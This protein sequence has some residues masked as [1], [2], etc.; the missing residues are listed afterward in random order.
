MR[1]TRTFRLACICLTAL[2]STPVLADLYR[3]T[4]IPLGP[5][6]GGNYF[7]TYDLNNAGQVVGGGDA[8]GRDR[9]WLW[10]GGELTIV[11]P[12]GGGAAELAAINS[13]GLAVGS[14]TING[15]LD[16]HAVLWDG[17]HMKDLGLPPGASSSI[18]RA[19]ND[20]GQVVVE[21]R[22]ANGAVR[23]YLWNG[24]SFID[25]GTLGAPVMR[26]T[27]INL[28]GHVTGYSRATP[29]GVNSAVVWNG[30]TLIDLGSLVP[31]RRSSNAE[32]INN[33]GQVAGWAQVDWGYSQAFLW[34]GSTAINL[35]TLGGLIAAAY[36]VN[37][38]GQVVG[39]S[40][41]VS[42]G[43]SHAFL[44]DRAQGG[45]LDLNSYL[46]SPGD[47]L[48]EQ[49]FQINDA[50]QI[51]ARGENLVTGEYYENLLLTPVPEPA[52]AAL[53]LAGLALL[54]TARAARRPTTAA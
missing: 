6:S 25:I 22:F 18:G 46:E 36:D 20:N 31:D 35:G 17:S 40:N 3:V 15:N 16:F 28:A 53:W 43:A 1:V 7:N 5:F 26:A 50:G 19:I 10:N 49:A 14:S 45:M 21:G 39:F 44:W 32:A 9:G 24:A 33:A 48:I 52:T 4:P 23:A 8:A 12:L 42:L 41:T 29:N 11:S 37:N 54:L 47:W 27:D 38:R 13:A 2:V 34:E 51:V 30:S